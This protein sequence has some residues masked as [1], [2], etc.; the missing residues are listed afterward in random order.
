M[1][2]TYSVA[3]FETFG[4]PDETQTAR[5][6]AFLLDVLPLPPA[7]VL[8]APCGFGRHACALSEKGYRVTGID[9]NLAVA[10]EARLGDVEVYQLD[11]RWLCELPGSFDAVICMWASFGWFDDATDVLEQMAEKMRPGG[12]LVLDVYDPVWFRGHQG[13]HVIERNGR[14]AHGLRN[15][16][17][18][19]LQRSSTTRTV[20]RTCSNG[21]SMSPTS[22]LRLALS[23]GS[24][25]TSHAPTSTSNPNPWATH[26]ACS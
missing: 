7:S 5:E 3:W 26:R 21:G 22:C 13:P 11:M 8:D 20:R 14:V 10:G 16:A 2:Q 12:V 9:K 6:I 17:G 4:R 19:R 18:T 24:S 25:A 15:V 1:E 23:S